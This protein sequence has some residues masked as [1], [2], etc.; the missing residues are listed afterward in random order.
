[1]KQTKQQLTV[2]LFSRTHVCID[3][4]K[5]FLHRSKLKTPQ[6]ILFSIQFLKYFIYEI[7]YSRLK[8]IAFN[9]LVYVILYYIVTQSV[10][11]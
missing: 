6:E 7:I 2:M 5:Y 1:M 3:A 11:Q 9:F 10:I 8:N 4:Y